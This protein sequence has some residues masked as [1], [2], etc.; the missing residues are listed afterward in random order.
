[1]DKYR[2][3]EKAKAE[4]P[5]QENDIRIT[6]Q[7]KMRN[8]ISYATKL[9]QEKGVAEITLKAMGRA[10]N[11]T[12]TIA[13][14]IKR[15]I[16]GLYQITKIDSTDITD[17]WE[18]LEEGLDRVETTRHVSSIQITLSTKPL[19]DSDPG[20]QPPIPT[21]QVKA[22]FT[23]A[24]PPRE[25][26]GGIGGRGRPFFRGRGRGRGRGSMPVDQGPPPPEPPLDHGF[27]S[28]QQRPPRPRFR[29]RGRGR[30][31][32]RGGG[33]PPHAAPM[34][35][36]LPLDLPTDPA[37]FAPRGRG[38]G[39]FR[40]PR[41]ARGGPRGGGPPRGGLRRG[42]GRGADFPRPGSFA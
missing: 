30:G 8:Y 37:D 33:P 28:D 35:E 15:R 12:V 21:E 23:G 10:I 27:G 32:P 4:T 13:E 26:R 6:T 40:R 25:R 5:I 22:G 31:F 14:I 16:A 42:G 29:G 36:Q 17:V 38:R 34:P 41:R 1:M 39:A 11:K 24:P 18:P 7:G 20:Y 19:N 2:R 3:V 9:F